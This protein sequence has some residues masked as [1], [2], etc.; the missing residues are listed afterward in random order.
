MKKVEDIS[1]CL[2]V[3]YSIK[4]PEIIKGGQTEDKKTSREEDIKVFHHLDNANGERR[5]VYDI[6]QYLKK[7]FISTSMYYL[8]CMTLHATFLLQLFS[9]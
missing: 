7:A 2:P 6:P 5:E 9:E 8:Q 1:A 3:S 4:D